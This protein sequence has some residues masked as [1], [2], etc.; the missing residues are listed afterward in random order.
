M[1]TAKRR[2]RGSGQ[3]QPAPGGRPC[4]LTTQRLSVVKDLLLLGAFLQREASRLLEAHCLN[5]QQ[6]VV[7]KEIDERGPLLQ[8]D[9][10]SALLFEKSN[11]SKIVAKLVQLRLVE[12]AAPPEDARKTVLTANSRGREVIGRAMHALDQWNAAWLAAL[13]DREIAN[14]L[15]TLEKLKKGAG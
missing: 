12:V 11:V 4:S 2:A 15:A 6:F 7:L 1:D 13:D 3:R 5:Q 9:L 14:V 8:K 10:C